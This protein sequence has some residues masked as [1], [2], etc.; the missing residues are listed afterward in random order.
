M[1]DVY[2]TLHVM[3]CSIVM[4]FFF[5][6][7][8]SNSDSTHLLQRIHW[9]ASVLILHF[10]KSVPMKKQT[11]LEWPEDEHN[12]IFGELFFKVRCK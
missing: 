5:S 3:L 10:S 6:Y 7:L 4:F 1:M 8:D 12:S 2:F 11:H 9:W